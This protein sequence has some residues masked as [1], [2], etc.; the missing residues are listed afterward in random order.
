VV[1]GTHAEGLDFRFDR[2][3]FTEGLA[4]SDHDELTKLAVEIGLDEAEVR[5]VLG[6]GTQAWGERSPLTPPAGAD[7]GDACEGDSCAV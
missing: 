6:S 4:V 1:G 5:E 3:T 7:G 2:G